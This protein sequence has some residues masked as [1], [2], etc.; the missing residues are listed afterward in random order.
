MI[1]FVVFGFSSFFSVGVKLTSTNFLDILYEAFE[2][3]QSGTK[4]PQRL[5]WFHREANTKL[6]RDGRSVFCF[7][8]NSFEALNI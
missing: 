6:I 7:L 4:M 5:I 2:S 3:Q 1:K 8:L